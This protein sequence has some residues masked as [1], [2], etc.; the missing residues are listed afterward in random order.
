[1]PKNELELKTI[2]QLRGY[3][4]IIPSYQ[5]GY[6]WKKEQVE[7]LIQDIEEFQEKK[8]K[9]E[10]EFYCLQPIVV[11]RRTQKGKKLG[12]CDLNGK[13][14]GGSIKLE[15]QNDQFVEYKYDVENQGFFEHNCFEVIDG[16]QR[17]T[18]IFLI[19]KHLENKPPF[20]LGYDTRTATTKVLNDQEKASDD[21]I[22][23]WHIKK[24]KETIQ[25]A[26]PAPKND[27]AQYWQK[28]L[29]GR[30]KV[31]WYEPEGLAEGDKDSIEVFQRLNVGKIPLTNSELIRALFILETKGK[32]P[33]ELNEYKIASEWDFI[34]QQLHNDEFW[35]FCN[36]GDPFEKKE[37]SNRI[38]FLFNL[39]EK[40]FGDFKDSHK[41]YSTFAMY[42]DWLSEKPKNP[43]EDIPVDVEHLW[44]EIKNLYYRF[45]EW[46]IDDNLYHLIGFIRLNHWKSLTELLKDADDQKQSKL[47]RDMLILAKEKV[48]LEEMNNWCYGENST[49]IQNALLL[50]NLFSY[51][52]EGRRFPWHRYLLKSD[53]GHRTWSLEHIN[54][55][56]Q[57]ELE[58]AKWLD[59]AK[60][61][62]KQVEEDLYLK[63]SKELLEELK[64]ELEGLDN[65]TPDS[66]LPK[67]RFSEVLNKLQGDIQDHEHYIENLALLD[68]DDNSSLNN[69]IFSQKRKK[70]RGF[71]KGSNHFIPLTTRDVFMK[72]YSEGKVSMDKWEVSDCTSYYK[73]IAEVFNKNLPDLTISTKLPKRGDEN[74]E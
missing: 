21:Q 65:Y 47:Q 46:F 69:S 44:Q 6:R 60:K 24:A 1:M 36:L 34:E 41:T 58:G 43:R 4:F 25:F 8:N 73:A 64:K 49:Q 33:A 5:R 56:N 26:F 18:T 57:Q 62:T 29:L 15:E 59:W 45:H 71:C 53:G 12:G 9:S 17:L 27:A 32:P 63:D 39:V 38:E 28:T 51:Q 67:K 11:K 10:K 48:K 66:E 52:K 55:Q 2:E 14:V 13:I 37:Y 7:A 19:L 40:R 70:I 61:T 3:H 74:N 20:E 23:E 35:C 22:D 72:V 30:T 50:F 31:I 68:R 42:S 16:Q 54:A